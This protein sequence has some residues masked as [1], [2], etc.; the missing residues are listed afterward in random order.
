MA[1]LAGGA[2]AADLGLAAGAAAAGLPLDLGCLGSG[3]AGALAGPVFGLMAG[4]ANGAVVAY[5]V[6]GTGSALTSALVH[7]LVGV[8]AAAAGRLGALRHPGGRVAAGAAAGLV[9]AAA[10][11]VTS[12][13]GPGGSPLAAFLLGAGRGATAVLVGLGVAAEVVEKAVTFLLVGL[14]I[15]RLPARARWLGVSPR[16]PP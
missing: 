1:A 7:G 12:G 15:E 5:L 8:S 3:L 6:P 14:L 11:L 9:T 13:L 2:L 10:I 4:L 16:R